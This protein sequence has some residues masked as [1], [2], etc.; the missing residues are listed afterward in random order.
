MIETDSDAA[1]RSARFQQMALPHLDAAFNLARWLCGNPNDAED[2]VQDA[3]IRAFRYFDMFHGDNARPWLLTIVRRTWYTEWQKRE[4]S[5]HSVE[6]DENLDDA[7]FEGWSEPNAD[8]ETLMIRDQDARLVHAALEQLPAE[9]REVMV[10]RELEELSYREIATIAD[11]PVGTVMSRLAR[12]RRR[13]A[14]SLA[15]LQARAAGK[16]A[17]SR[18]AAAGAAATATGGRGG[19][20]DKR[21]GGSAVG[22]AAAAPA[23]APG[24]MPPGALANRAGDPSS[25]GDRTP[26]HSSGPSP[27][28]PGA[29]PGG[30]AQENP[31]GL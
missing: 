10:L 25:A 26:G 27:R 12:G 3:Y 30:I 21:C 7:T 18:G 24:T 14:E 8:P 31:D 20:R 28:N 6:F 5:R 13:L 15:S 1:Q 16:P 23:A 19:A 17:P 11:L 22:G 2:I 29:T 9:Y 4:M